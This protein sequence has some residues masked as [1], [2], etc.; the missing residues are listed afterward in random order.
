MS[1]KSIMRSKGITVN[2]LA[3]KLGISRQ[4]ASVQINGDVLKKSA[5]AIADILGVPHWQLLACPDELMDCLVK[6]SEGFV[7]LVT[8]G[9]NY[10]CATS[11]AELKD[12]A[13]S[14]KRNAIFVDYVRQRNRDYGLHIKD[15]LGYYGVTIK[16][17]A[18]KIGVT[19]GY[20]SKIANGGCDFKMSLVLK[21]ANAIGCPVEELLV[22]YEYVPSFLAVIKNGDCYYTLSSIDELSDIW[23]KL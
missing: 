3:E 7:A 5:V 9:N 17:C 1:I 21:I 20:L 22:G 2:D 19:R 15:V 10:Y 4:A 23:G 8:N 12:I 14:L 18:E 11:L 13:I 16:E 6:S